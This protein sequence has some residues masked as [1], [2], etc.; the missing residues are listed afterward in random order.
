ML[1]GMN[2]QQELPTEHLSC[3]VCENRQQDLQCQRCHLG[4]CHECARP[5]Q[6]CGDEFDHARE[7]IHSLTCPERH[8]APESD[9]TAN[10]ASKMERIEEEPET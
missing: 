10:M 5:C 1:A 2:V 7:L 8:E 3:H 4:V 6:Y 9:L